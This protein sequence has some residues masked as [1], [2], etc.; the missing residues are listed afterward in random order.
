[1][2]RVLKGRGH[3]TAGK[4]VGQ[5]FLRQKHGRGGQ[6]LSGIVPPQQRNKRRIHADQ[7]QAEAVECREPN[8]G[9]ISECISPPT[10]SRGSPGS[11]SAENQ[12][13]TRITALEEKD[14]PCVRSA[15]G[16]RPAIRV[17]RPVVPVRLWPARA[18][19][20]QT[21]DS[22]GASRCIAGLNRA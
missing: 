11:N 2:D 5:E 19:T 15:P 9:G 17:G 12:S 10:K 13:S 6:A 8:A 1:M 21:G 20:G 3:A 4:L 18:G 16:A 7:R 14:V 22:R